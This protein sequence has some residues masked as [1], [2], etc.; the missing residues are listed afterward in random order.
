MLSL[1]CPSQPCTFIYLTADR[2]LEAGL[3]TECLASIFIYLLIEMCKEQTNR[4][5]HGYILYAFCN[6]SARQQKS[7]RSSRPQGVVQHVHMW[8]RL[9]QS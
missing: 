5:Q 2:Q 3:T 7:Q 1:S 4:K 6:G 9:M 8:F